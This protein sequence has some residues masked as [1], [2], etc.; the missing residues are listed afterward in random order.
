MARIYPLPTEAQQLTHNIIYQHPT[1]L[2]DIV[3]KG[4]VTSGIVY[5]LGVCQLA[6]TYTF[7][8]V[9]GTSAGAIAAAATAAAE[10][11]RHSDNGGFGRIARLPRE[12]GAEGKLLSLFQPQPGT[13]RLFAL[14]IAFVGSKRGRIPRVVA[15]MSRSFGPISC[16]VAA[17]SARITA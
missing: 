16:P 2:C 10:L 4:G 7:E 3:M 9:G 11:G 5:P 13:R 1:K 8:D 6:K 15:A 14:A 12:L 17:R